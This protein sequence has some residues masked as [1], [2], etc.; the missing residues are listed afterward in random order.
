MQMIFTSAMYD[1][2]WRLLSSQAEE[3]I[4]TLPK[5]LKTQKL[6]QIFGRACAIIPNFKLLA[7]IIT[8]LYGVVLVPTKVN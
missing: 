6:V 3:P 7:F 2:S 1:S 5:Y 4:Q 8:K